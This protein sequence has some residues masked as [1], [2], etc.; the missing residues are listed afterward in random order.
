MVLGTESRAFALNLIP[1]P[2]KIIITFILRQGLACWDYK[3]A[4]PCLTHFIFSTVVFDREGHFLQEGQPRAQIART[5]A[6]SGLSKLPACLSLTLS[7]STRRGLQLRPT[8]L[9]SPHHEPTIPTESM[10]GKELAMLPL[11]GL[12]G[13]SQEAL[14]LLWESSWKPSWVPGLQMRCCQ[15]PRAG[16]GALRV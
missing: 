4:L 1:K 3:Y 15:L 6:E 7:V 12:A 13:R 8:G 10:A 9:C 16:C 14:P 11:P 5:L 2:F